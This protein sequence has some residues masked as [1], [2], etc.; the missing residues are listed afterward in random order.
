MPELN[1]EK[2]WD[3][4]VAKLTRNWTLH[5]FRPEEMLEQ[6]A[7]RIFNIFA[8]IRSFDVSEKAL[9]QKLE[10]MF[11][12]IK[13]ELIQSFVRRKESDKHTAEIVAEVKAWP[14]EP[15]KK[16]DWFPQKYYHD[17]RTCITKKK[18][19]STHTMVPFLERFKGKKKTSIK[20]KANE[21]TD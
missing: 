8:W 12:E 3:K 10:L 15:R 17:G 16:I 11:E 18:F 19:N 21:S 6:E 9:L 13:Q 20:G 1:N 14:I 7:V 2:E 5:E 4:V